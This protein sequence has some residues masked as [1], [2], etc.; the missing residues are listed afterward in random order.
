MPPFQ[1]FTTKA[2]EIV[3]RSH[4][5]AIERGQNHVSHM[6]LFTAILL[7]EENM[8]ISILEKLDIDIITKDKFKMLAILNKD[9]PALADSFAA[10]LGLTM[11]ILNDQANT[12]GIK[13][14]LTGVPETF[15]INKKGIVVRKFLGPAQWNA[16]RY[17]QMIEQFMEQ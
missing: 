8:V 7:Q 15:I 3:R 14:G 13:Y 12:V 10:K 9:E 2:K 1:N 6:H 11:P 16:P 5:L 17:I 4:E